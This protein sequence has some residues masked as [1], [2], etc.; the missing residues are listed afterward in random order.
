MR[1]NRS[2]NSATDLC[3]LMATVIS[4]K[5]FSLNSL[6][7]S[8]SVNRCEP[9][10]DE[11]F[12]SEF[13][14]NEGKL[15]LFSSKAAKVICYLCAMKLPR[16]Y[17]LE[18]IA[19]ISGTTFIG[20]A[21]HLVTGINE[22]HK[23]EIGDLVFVDHPKYYEKALQSAATTILI[24]QEVTAPE[25]KALLF[26]DDPFRDY[27]KLTR[28]FSPQVLSPAQ[29]GPNVD[30]HPSAFVHPSVVI[31]HSVTIGANTIIHP[32]VVI[33]NHVH[34]G[35]NCIVHA[36][37]VLGSDAFYY[38]ARPTGR[39]KMHSCGSL[40]IENDVEIGA[41]CTIDRGVSGDTRIGEGTKIDNSVHIGHDTVV[42]KH[43]LMA[44]QVGIAGCVVLEDHVI[45]WGQVGIASG[46]KIEKNAVVLGQCGVTKNLEGNK[47]YFGSPAEEARQKYKELA[48]LRKLPLAIETLGI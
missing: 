22:I 3:S 18:E 45:L 4:N 39:E 5:A 28:H 37:A 11:Q 15:A 24:N 2:S 46:L 6:C 26:S 34:I 47:T 13:R 20:P 12:R 7:R 16:P 8:F 41:G 35:E 32:G 44:A 38:K 27:N 1:S 9:I 23:V 14:K 21:S 48:S 10:I 29:V 31:G 17:T 43:C 30:I 42:G 25:G 33:Y 19:Q 36:N 40:E